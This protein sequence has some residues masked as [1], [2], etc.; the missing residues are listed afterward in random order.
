MAFKVS[1]PMAGCSICDDRAEGL[2]SPASGPENSFSVIAPPLYHLAAISVNGK[3]Q[4][5]ETWSG[6]HPMARLL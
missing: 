4:W 5:G 2:A 3:C 1:G 6:V